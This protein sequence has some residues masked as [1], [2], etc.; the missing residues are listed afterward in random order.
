M[1]QPT[2]RSRWVPGSTPGRLCRQR[3]RERRD[4]G[5]HRARR[6]REHDRAARVAGGRGRAPRVDGRRRR[7][8]ASTA[9]G[10][11]QRAVDVRGREAGLEVVVLRPG[12]LSGRVRG[13]PASG[14]QNALRRM[15]RPTNTARRSGPASSGGSAEIVCTASLT[16]FSAPAPMSV[17]PPPPPTCAAG[18]RRVTDPVPVLDHA[19]I[20]APGARGH[21]RAGVTI[22]AM[23]ETTIQAG[24]AGR[25]PAGRRPGG[26][27]AARW[28][29]AFDRLGEADRAS[30]L[31][32]ADLESLSTAATFSAEAQAGNEVKERAY[33]AYVAEGNPLRRP[34]SPSTSP[35]SSSGGPPFDRIRMDA[36]GGAPPQGPA[37][38]VCPRVPRAAPQRDGGDDRRARRGAR[39]SPSRRSRS[40]TASPTRTCAPSRRRTS[41][42]SR[43]PAATRRPGSR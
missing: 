21:R 28:R 13:R 9:D 34:T 35:T 31:G 3:G 12:R 26:H 43:S 33:R 6:R 20:F 4:L 1:P 24:D 40:A 30:A 38:V 25:R 15:I 2:A 41:A 23:A 10:L 27:R 7:T 17:V 14:G 8:P 39:R 32:G 16:N 5:L 42:S 37:R 36:P 18:A 19:R 29:E 11:E 22:R